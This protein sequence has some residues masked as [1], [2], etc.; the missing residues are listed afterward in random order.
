MKKSFFAFL[1]I[2]FLFEGSVFQLLLPQAWGS[3]FVVIPQLVVSGV[4][5][6]SLYLPKRYV[7]IFAISFGLLHDIVYGPAWG[8]TAFT[9]ALVAYGT[10]MLANH[11]PPFTWIVGVAVVVGQLGFTLLIYGWYRLFGF[12]EMPFLYSF[13]THILPTLVFNAIA[14]YPIFRF[15]H[16]IYVKKRNRQV[17]FDTI[18]R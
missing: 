14:A 10:Y 12:T 9:L 11:F 15:I 18:I 6:I 5:V 16:Y 1:F 13:V 3:N 2:T 7:L 8:I 17:V 4:I